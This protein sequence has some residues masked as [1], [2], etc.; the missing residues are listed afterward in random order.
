M[1]STIGV[2]HLINFGSPFL[3]SSKALACSSNM[4]KTSLGE[5]QRSSIAVSGWSERPFPVLLVYF[6]KAASSSASKLEAGVVVLMDE[7]EGGIGITGGVYGPARKGKGEIATV[8]PSREMPKD[9]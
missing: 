9:I 7:L 3:N 1:P 6:V 8:G 5:L 4:A 2:S